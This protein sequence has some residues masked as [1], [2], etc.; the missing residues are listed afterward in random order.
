LSQRG[1]VDL[2]ASFW[3]HLE[4]GTGL[5]HAVFGAN[6]VVFIEAWRFGD[7]SGLQRLKFTPF[8]F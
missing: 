1:G 4:G 2:L 5:I 7:Q 8:S 3:D 6:R